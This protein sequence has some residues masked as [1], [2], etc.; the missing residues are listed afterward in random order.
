MTCVCLRLFYFQ[1]KINKSCFLMSRYQTKRF[2]QTNN[3]KALSVSI[4]IFRNTNEII[5]V[6]RNACFQ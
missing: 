6:K 2:D 3:K 5:G 1:K 4:Y